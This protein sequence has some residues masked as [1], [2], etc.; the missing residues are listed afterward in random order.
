MY[1]RNTSSFIQISVPDTQR[2]NNGVD[3]GLFVIAHMVEFCISK[4]FSSSVIFDTKKIREQLTL[5][6]QQKHFTEFPKTAES[7]N[8]RK[9]KPIKLLVFICIARVICP[10]VLS[11]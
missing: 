3:C 5:Y 10:A 6:L 2:Q 7:L 4:T 9:K 11:S 8:D 1:G